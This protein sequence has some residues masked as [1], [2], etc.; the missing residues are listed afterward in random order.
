MGMGRGD[1]GDRGATYAV[2]IYYYSPAMPVYFVRHG[3]CYN[4]DTYLLWKCGRSS[5]IPVLSIRLRR[6]TLGGGLGSEL[7]NT[8]LFTPSSD[9]SV[10]PICDLFLHI[11]TGVSGVLMCQPGKNKSRSRCCSRKPGL[12]PIHRPSLTY[13]RNMATQSVSDPENLQI[14]KSSGSSLLMIV[15]KCK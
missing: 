7:R 1:R 8:L 14:Y 3:F 2:V 12:F 9:I 5:G 4:F 10:R 15:S 11:V 6:A 13:E